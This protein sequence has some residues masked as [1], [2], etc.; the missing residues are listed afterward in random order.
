MLRKFSALITVLI[1]SVTF[2]STTVFANTTY[3]MNKKHLVV[4]V[5]FTETPESLSTY[6]NNV[7][8]DGTLKYDGTIKQDD[9]YYSNLF[10]GTT[11][12]TVRNYYREVSD[13]KLD[14]IPAEETC[15]FG[16]DG[17]VR[18]KIPIPYPNEHEQTG[19]S[20][21]CLT[22]LARNMILEAL[23]TEGLTLDNSV[24]FSQFDVNS[25]NNV[26]LSGIDDDELNISLVLAGGEFGPSTRAFCY[27]YGFDFDNKHMVGDI[28]FENAS[29]SL[30]TLCH[31]T[32]HLRTAI[33][34]YN[35][36][37]D[38]YINKL[39]PMDSAANSHLDP[40][41]KIKM[42][43]VTPTLVTSSGNYT[44]NAT[45]PEN[46][47]QYN[48]LKIP[49]PCE[50]NRE[51]YFLVENRQMT[52]FDS[53]LRFYEPGGIAIYHV[54]K[55]PSYLVK[56]RVER[57]HVEYIG[58]S[59]IGEVFYCPYM[60]DGSTGNNT[61]GPNTSPSNSKSFSGDN[62]IVTLT[63]NGPSSSSM[64]VNVK[65]LTPPQNFK[66]TSDDT[67]IKLSWEPHEDAVEYAVSVDNGEF[68]S[69][70]SATSY[71]LPPSIGKHSYKV[72]V[73]D[74]NGGVVETKELDT[75]GVIFGDVDRDGAVTTSDKSLI[76]EY[77]LD[78]NYSL[79]DT[80]IL[81]ADVNGSGN[82]DAM[83]YSLITSY[84]DGSVS[85]FPVGQFKVITYGDVNGDGLITIED[86]NI[87]KNN[88]DGPNGEHTLTD[89][90]QRIAAQVSYCDWTEVYIT[91]TDASLIKEY[92]DGQRRYFPILTDNLD[93]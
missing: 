4:L 67:N 91:S 51:E 33:D 75:K 16:N 42:G 6:P 76:L 65:L 72:R 64:S 2:L 9:T 18:V 84:L 34:L 26:T 7:N 73:K 82:I 35:L 15:G 41:N 71:F 24:N 25:D 74:I 56:I 31:E 27:M 44:V 69:V 90:T 10:F 87:V 92:L 48:V 85:Q 38:T 30:A 3:Q 86:Y 29:S 20:V 52:G 5:E 66:V 59:E 32:A 88:P 1:L 70:G 58:Q 39:S 37:Y 8:S 40:Y 22:T 62:G 54:K 53:D 14:Y 68:V 77:L 28:A 78:T 55:A 61:F 63:I 57:A 83:D 23:F 13:G 50:N 81:A 46:P 21:G 93:I 80:Q 11:G 36:G 12:R 49:I 45:D 19:S 43:F 17:V 60:Y 79:T 47:G 89:F